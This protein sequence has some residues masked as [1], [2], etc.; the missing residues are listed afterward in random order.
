MGTSPTSARTV[1]GTRVRSPHGR[2][3]TGHP[4][5]RVAG[6]AIGAG[7]VSVTI[8]EPVGHSS[9]EY[10]CS[11]DRGCKRHASS[12]MRCRVAASFTSRYSTAGSIPGSLR[13]GAARDVHAGW[14]AS[15]WP[16]ES[17]SPRSARRRSRT[18]YVGEMFG[19]PFAVS[20]T[21]VD[22]ERQL[23]SQH[24]KRL[25]A[26]RHSE[27]VPS[28]SSVSSSARARS[29]AGRCQCNRAAGAGVGPQPG[30]ISLP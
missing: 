25:V 9:M 10:G 24:R 13:C 4:G 27:R 1:G 12:A 28:R 11:A 16:R 29:S 26:R 3:G 19:A 21:R 8:G 30:R 6:A 18:R 22:A 5:S 17:L 14:Q 15:A 7:S 23:E 20:L 2:V